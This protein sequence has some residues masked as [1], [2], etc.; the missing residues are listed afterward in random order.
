MVE[1]TASVRQL[2]IGEQT[3]ERAAGG[4]FAQDPVD[5]IGIG[6]GGGLHRDVEAGHVDR[7]HAYGFGL[8]SP[9]KFRQQALD[10]TRQTGGHRD[11]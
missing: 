2:G 8:N 5:L 7:R 10:T 6:R 11:H 1:I 4:G 3:F 9:G